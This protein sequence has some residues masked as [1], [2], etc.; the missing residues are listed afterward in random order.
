[1]YLNILSIPTLFVSGNLFILICV[2]FTKFLD[3]SF[4][5]S[6]ITDI[7][8]ELSQMSGLTGQDMNALMAQK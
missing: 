3:A 7:S 8:S 5:S 6:N 2:S 4:V 1:M